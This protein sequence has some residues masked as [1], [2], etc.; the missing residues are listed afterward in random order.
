[1]WCSK[2]RFSGT[3]KWAFRIFLR[4]SPSQGWGRNVVHFCLPKV[5]TS[6]CRLGVVMMVQG[7]QDCN[8]WEMVFRC[9][10]DQ[11]IPQLGLGVP[12]STTG[13]VYLLHPLRGGLFGG[14]LC[15]AHGMSAP[16]AGAT[17]YVQVPS[18]RNVSVSVPNWWGVCPGVQSSQMN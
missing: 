10:E 11:G 9:I 15:S 5:R 17:G 13:P 18:V 4:N 3:S 14:A 8:S 1:V 12:V 6:V 2:Y 7:R 16:R